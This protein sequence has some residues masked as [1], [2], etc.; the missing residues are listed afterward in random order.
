MNQIMWR[1]TEEQA[2]IILN[3][4]A[5]KPYKDVGGLI[6]NLV[7]QSNEQLKAAQQEA[8]Q[9]AMVKAQEAEEAKPSV[10]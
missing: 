5:E 2:N 4:L 8:Q 10:N 9:Q 7:T 3:I 6:S 1:L